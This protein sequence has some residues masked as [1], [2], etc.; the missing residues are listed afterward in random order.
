MNQENEKKLSVTGEVVM[1]APLFVIFAEYLGYVTP[2]SKQA[3]EWCEGK[4]PEAHIQKLLII[5]A[6]AILHQMKVDYTDEDIH[7]YYNQYRPIILEEFEEKLHE[8]LAK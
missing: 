5:E 6:K 4:L 8:A 2:L 1:E 3:E 7:Y